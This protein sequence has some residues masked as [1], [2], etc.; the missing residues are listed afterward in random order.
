MTTLLSAVYR[1]P[2]EDV[3]VALLQLTYHSCTRAVVLSV[4][5]VCR[6]KKNYLS[7]CHQP[8]T[9]SMS[10][11]NVVDTMQMR[12]SKMNIFMK[13]WKKMNKLLRMAELLCYS[14]KCHLACLF[15]C[16][17]L[18]L[19]IVLMIQSYFLLWITLTLMIAMMTVIVIKLFS[20]AILLLSADI[21][22]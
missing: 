3:H 22:L 21:N 4:K 15:C 9:N 7:M 10:I 19:T 14:L 8:I 20:F 13:V 12:S 6:F 5:K 2:N 17:T 11:S 1:L 16:G 18:T